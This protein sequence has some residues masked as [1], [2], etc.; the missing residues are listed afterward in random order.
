M[1]N[2]GFRCRRRRRGPPEVG[3]VGVGFAGQKH[4]ELQAPGDIGLHGAQR[5]FRLSHNRIVAF[6][7]AELDQADICRP[8]GLPVR[9]TSPI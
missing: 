6:F 3:V 4:F 1:P 9:S 7:L 2:P 8:A 5:F